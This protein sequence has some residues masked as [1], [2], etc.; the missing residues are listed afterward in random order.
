MAESDK[1]NDTLT[2]RCPDMLK[3]R[4]N[5]IALGRGTKMSAMLLAHME[6]VV[7]EEERYIDSIADIFG[8][9]R[10]V[11]KER[12]VST[13]QNDVMRIEDET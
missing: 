8:Y 9:A 3:T 2:I 11:I 4:F 7:E 1:S 6:S 5:R 12:R 10:K 13:A